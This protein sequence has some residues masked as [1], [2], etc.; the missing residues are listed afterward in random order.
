MTAPSESEN[1]PAL[2]T[3]EDLPD[4]WV[5]FIR[6]G[7]F[8]K[9]GWSG[10]PDR[11]RDGLATGSPF[12]LE[13]IGKVPGSVLDERAFHAAF[14]HLRANGEWFAAKPELIAFMNWAMRYS[15]RQGEAVVAL[16]RAARNEVEPTSGGHEPGTVSRLGTLVAASEIREAKWHIREG[17]PTEA[18]EA[19][20]RGL[21]R[22]GLPKE[23]P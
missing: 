5:Y 11:R 10:D 9:I 16:G 22:L 20:D 6:G 13:V 17:R 4:G 14:A 15:D 3:D 21:W 8:V 7:D 19:L 12:E 18:V 23:L 2:P 1:T